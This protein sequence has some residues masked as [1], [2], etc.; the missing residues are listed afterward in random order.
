[1]LFSTGTFRKHDNEGIVIAVLQELN[2]EDRILT[3]ARVH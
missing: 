3:H 1:L 2:D